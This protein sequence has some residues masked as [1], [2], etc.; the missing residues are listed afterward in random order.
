MKRPAESVIMKDYT[1]FEQLQQTHLCPEYHAFDERLQRDWWCLPLVHF[2]ICVAL[3]YGLL[4]F[5]F[6]LLK[7]AGRTANMRLITPW[8]VREVCGDGARGR[9]H[10][11]TPGPALLPHW[12]LGSPA[13]RAQGTR[14]ASSGLA[15]SCLGVSGKE[16]LRCR[17]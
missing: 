10:V 2:Y 16:I 7:L 17:R 12:R 1:M 5:C 11:G 15:I 6:L 4:M 14:P 3:F 8:I 9:S 13:G